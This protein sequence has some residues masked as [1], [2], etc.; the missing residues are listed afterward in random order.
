MARTP[1]KHR[2]DRLPVNLDSLFENPVKKLA[3]C[4]ITTDDQM[5]KARKNTHGGLVVPSLQ[6]SYPETFRSDIVGSKFLRQMLGKAAVLEATQVEL[7]SQ[8]R[9]STPQCSRISLSVALELNQT[10]NELIGTDSVWNSWLHLD[11]INEMLKSM[12][13]TK[14]P[15]VQDS[16]H[17]LKLYLQE[18]THS[19]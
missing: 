18:Y 13:P 17:A 16:Q 14:V 19:A 12:P 2:Y 4:V 3:M 15:D 7:L 6:I 9:P 1:I 8:Y 11:E 10:S 5:V